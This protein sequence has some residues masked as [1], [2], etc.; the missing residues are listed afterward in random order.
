MQILCIVSQRTRDVAQERNACAVL[1]SKLEA[2]VEEGTLAGACLDTLLALLAHSPLNQQAFL[3]Q[4]GLARVMLL[5]SH[6]S[7]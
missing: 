6:I 4:Q 3:A 1:L 5:L 2:D 7:Q